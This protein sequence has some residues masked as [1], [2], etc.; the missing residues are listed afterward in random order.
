MCRLAEESGRHADLVL[1][2]AFT[3]LRW[4][5]AIALTVA[6][7]EFLKRRISVH[8]NAVQVGQEFKVGQTKGKENRTVPVA[9]SVLARLAVRCRGRTEKDLLFP[10]RAGGY[11][12]RPSYDSTGW[13]NRAVER[14]QVQTITPHDLRHTCAS[15]AVSS[16]ANVLAVSRMLGHKDPSVTLRVY[17]DLFDSDL[18]AVA[19]NL[20]AKIS[21]SVQNV[22]KEPVDRRR[23]RS[24]PAV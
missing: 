17:A 2:L 9:E 8:S 16:G 5:E 20:D 13:F 22:S 21:G 11:L 3:G 23:S 6:D 10:A 12:K 4:G 19:V 14:A 15:L 1:V 24:K 18:D 7:V